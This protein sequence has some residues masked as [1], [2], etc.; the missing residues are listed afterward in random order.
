MVK[1]KN[2]TVRF[3]QIK[4]GYVVTYVI[5]DYN[6]KGGVGKTS[7]IIN[8][9]CQMA[10][11]GKR[12]LLIDGDSQMNLSQ[13]FFEEDDTIFNPDTGKI[14]EGVDTLYETLEEDLNIFNVIQTKEYSARRKW[15]NKFKKIGL[16]IDVV[17]GSSDMDYYGP[18]E[19]SIDILRKK[20]DL[21]D[22]F[23]DYIFIDFPPAH[24]L[25][26]MMYLVA[27]D[28]IIVPMHLAK[29]S[30]INGYFDVI[31]KC[32]EAR[33]E[34]ANKNLRVLGLFYINVQMYKN[35]QSSTWNESK[36]DGTKDELEMFDTLIR[37][38]YRSTQISELN[39]SPVCICCPSSDV[40]ED[41]S[42]LAKE[43]EKRI[44]KQRG[45]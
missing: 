35:D 11:E 6:R 22:G 36:E 24:N 5:G 3:L 10:L 8:I 1:N 34:Y 28:Y 14:R 12:V 18:D 44:K 42:H 31:D 38:D 37:H 26:T 27:C 7:S 40:S 29:G 33:K 4:G 25:V 9:A 17:L 16:K 32:K 30:S 13:F 15:K 45:E 43:I 21:L 39:Q 23:Y 41:Y 20:L 2:L 19:N